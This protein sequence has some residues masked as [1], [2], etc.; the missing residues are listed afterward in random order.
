MAGAGAAGGLEGGPEVEAGAL[1]G[2]ALP[3]GTGSRGLWCAGDGGLRERWWGVGIRDLHHSFRGHRVSRFPP[4][5][6]TSR[7]GCPPTN[8]TWEEGWTA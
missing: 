3:R 4:S 5:P 7:G 6:E 8:P 2:R 1:G